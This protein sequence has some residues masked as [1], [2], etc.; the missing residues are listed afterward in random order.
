MKV[1]W[2]NGGLRIEP[3]DGPETDALMIVLRSMRLEIP[4]EDDAPRCGDGAQL[5]S[6]SGSELFGGGIGSTAE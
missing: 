6:A 4:P 1:S 5:G 2:Y 3:K